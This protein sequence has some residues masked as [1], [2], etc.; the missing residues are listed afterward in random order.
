MT[1]EPE[2]KSA[3]GGRARPD[4]LE[5][6]RALNDCV[7]VHSALHSIFYHKSAAGHDDDGETSGV[8]Y[9]L[10]ALSDHLAEIRAALDQSR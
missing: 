2:L 10:N 9:L 6:D 7:R 3:G 5:I 1:D 4:V 8:L